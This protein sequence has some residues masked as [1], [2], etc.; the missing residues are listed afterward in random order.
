[1][2]TP[3]TK[4]QLFIISVLLVP[5]LVAVAELAV[6]LLGKR[7]DPLSIFVSSPQLQ[8]DT[9]GAT[10]GGMFEFDPLLCW[11]LKA[12][13]RDIWWDFTPVSTNGQHLRMDH[14]VGV[15]KGIRIVVLG[16][17]VTFGYRVPVAHDRQQPSRFDATEK[18]YPVLLESKLRAAFPGR[19]IEVL[20]L[21]C[22]GY[23]STQALAW[24]KRDIAKLKPDIVVACLG[25]N[26]VRSAGIAD[27]VA[28]PADGAQIFVRRLMGSSQLLL[29]IAEAGKRRASVAAT[30]AEPEPRTSAEEYVAHLVEMAEISRGHHAWFGILLPVYRDPNTAGIEPG[31]SGD[32]DEGLRMT[33]YREQ[34]RMETLARKIPALEI[35]ELTER[36]WP[37]NKELFG[38]RIH[39]NAA[40]HR[41]IAD[42]LE[43]F[44]AE[45]MA[46][47][48]SK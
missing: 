29:T 37:A 41:L 47:L 32:P 23:T 15:K 17:S 26:D 21:A 35:P 16:D 3:R 8:S 39:P 1:M 34:L 27:R 36:S 33:R 48:T 6:R 20:P 9:Q 7:V 11:R 38:E 24:L 43:E 22:P 10:T 12:K 44:L 28:M 25:W 45:P 2:T 18:P 5:L 46:S 30:P 31:E 13:L 42:R 4:L 40:G 19:E 14:D